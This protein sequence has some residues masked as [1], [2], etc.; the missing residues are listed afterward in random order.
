M[1]GLQSVPIKPKQE[2]KVKD[3]QPP[4]EEQAKNANQKNRFQFWKRKPKSPK[5]ARR[6]KLPSGFAEWEQ[7]D[8]E[9]YNLTSFYL[10][11]WKAERWQCHPMQSRMAYFRY[12]PK[13]WF[14]NAR[15]LHRVELEEWRKASSSFEKL[16]PKASFDLDY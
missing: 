6:N 5:T 16:D 1:P 14:G 10:R 7:M 4:Q 13:A 3:A 15:S 8:Q 11:L 2:K 9:T 12:I